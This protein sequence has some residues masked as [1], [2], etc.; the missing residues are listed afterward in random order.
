MCKSTVSVSHLIYVES[1]SKRAHRTCQK[2][3]AQWRADIIRLDQ[4]NVD[5]G[6]KIAHEATSLNQRKAGLSK[7]DR[8]FVLISKQSSDTTQYFFRRWQTK[9]RSLRE[10][11][12]TLSRL[13]TYYRQILYRKAW[14]QLQLNASKK[15]TH[16]SYEGA[17]GIGEKLVVTAESCIVESQKEASA[18]IRDLVATETDSLFETKSGEDLDFLDTLMSNE[19]LTK[20]ALLCED[21]VGNL[22]K[23]MFYLRTDRYNSALACF[24]AVM[25]KMESP[26]NVESINGTDIITIKSAVLGKV[27]QAYH[28]LGKYDTAIVFFNRQLS[29]GKEIDLYESQINALLGLGNCYF[30][31]CEFNYAHTLF[32]QAL[33]AVVSVDNV[34][35]SKKALTY[36]WLEKCLVALNRQNEASVV[37]SKIQVMCDN[38]KERVNAAL[39]EMDLL[40]QRMTELKFNQSCVVSL[41]VVSPNL[42]LLQQE[43]KKKQLLITEC[44]EKLADSTKQTAKFSE[45]EDHLQLELEVAGSTTKDRLVS[46][47]INGMS[48][49]VKTVELMR[50][51]NDQ[52]EV[53]RVK[54]NETINESDRIGLL[55]HNT[56]DE[57][58]RLDDRITTEHGPLMQ[59]VLK[60]RNYRCMEFNKS[61]IAH[62]DVTGISKGC[63]EL[64]VSTEGKELYLHNTTTGKLDMVFTGDEEGRHIGEINGHTSTITC[65]FFRG[66][67]IYTGGMDCCVMGWCTKTKKKLFV[68]RGHEAAVTC[69]FADNKQL[70]SGST[71]TTIIIWNGD[72]GSLLRRIH[73]HIR[74]VQHIISN[75]ISTSNLDMVSASF[76][77][78][79]CWTNT[80]STVSDI[81]H[82]IHKL[83]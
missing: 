65:A 75:T 76:D 6:N 28:K 50:R 37:A 19:D 79:F 48:Q 34:P 25:S 12:Q 26:E 61:N 15:S 58:A 83:F 45:L 73:G 14:R 81:L 27:G 63:I 36:S 7:L 5:I 82:L 40:K 24:I 77:T 67:R 2:Q 57:I 54:K 4:E 1:F 53:V 80:S 17:K 60:K 31:K 62:G 3:I 47:L 20:F 51:L 11:K 32:H 9:A 42:I 69:I 10:A 23:G 29:L 43:R 41:D 8:Q 18:L 52:L 46:R 74:G 56:K 68:G 55:I 59:R 66:N 21:D 39:S 13:A 38:R 78:M 33:T 30:S 49:E 44:M 35:S 70:V 71:D 64:M 72:N 16:V 22:Q